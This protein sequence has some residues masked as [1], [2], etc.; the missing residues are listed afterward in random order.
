[1]RSKQRKGESL[2]GVEDIVLGYEP[3]CNGTARMS[4]VWSDR[5]VPG[6]SVPDLW[7]SP[8]NP[9]KP[10]SAGRLPTKSPRTRRHSLAH[11]GTAASMVSLALASIY[12]GSAELTILELPVARR[13]QTFS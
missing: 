7:A 5:R 2:L 12:A 4:S 1:M 9:H 13:L 10:A 8:Q 3:G 11:G 6:E